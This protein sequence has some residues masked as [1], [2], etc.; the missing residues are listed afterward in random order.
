MK[1]IGIDIHPGK[2]S[3]LFDGEKYDDLS[4]SKLKEFLL[5]IE[6]DNDQRILIC[7]DAP[8][9]GP[10]DEIQEIRY[11]NSSNSLTKRDI[12]YFFTNNFG[13]NVNVKDTN[14]KKF[15]GIS[16]GNYSSLPHWTITKR[17][18]GLPIMGKYCKKELPFKHIH[19]EVEIVNTINNYIVEVHPGLAIWVWLN[20]KWDEDYNWQYKGEKSTLFQIKEDLNHLLFEEIKV[21]SS[22]KP[23]FEEIDDDDKLDSFIAWLLGYLWLRDSR[24]LV[25]VIG[26]QETGSFLLPAMDQL[27]TS[28]ENFIQNRK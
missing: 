24:G 14:E 10:R 15:K 19:S 25:N 8:L 17:L 5:P 20:K 13:F 28:F 18:F 2:N 23:K 12:E 11:K 6:E 16:V 21:N 22:L 4:S 1:I 3:T 27:K 26:N 7:C 9:T